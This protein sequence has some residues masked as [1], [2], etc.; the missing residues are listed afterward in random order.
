LKLGSKLAVYHSPLAIT[1]NPDK[2][3][4]AEENDKKRILVIEEEGFEA[5]T[6]RNG[7][8]A[9]RKSAREPFDLIVTD[10]RMPG[11]SGLDVLPGIRKLQPYAPILVI[12][13]FGGGEDYRKALERGATAYLEKPIHLMNLKRLIYEMLSLEEKG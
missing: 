1:A 9:F 10:I 2:R 12:T 5:D 4:H 13:A 11:L 8:E 3:D 7:S 6:I